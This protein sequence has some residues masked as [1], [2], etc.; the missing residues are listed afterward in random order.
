[1][2]NDLTAKVYGNIALVYSAQR[3]YAKALEWNIKAI[4]ILERVC[5]KEHLDTACK[6]INIAG[7]YSGLGNTD[8]ALEFYGKAVTINENHGCYLNASGV[9]NIIASVYS[10]QGDYDKALDIYHNKVMVIF[11]QRLNKKHAA[12]ATLCNNIAKVYARRGDNTQALEWFLRAYRICLR[13]VGDPNLDT[14]RMA[15]D[16]EHF[17]SDLRDAY[18]LAGMFESPGKKY[19]L[20]FDYWLQQNMRIIDSIVEEFSP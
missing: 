7:N 6:Y 20:V 18:H 17:L 2:E 13:K 19:C 1:M 16:T 8:K 14:K 12:S 5:G 10:D 15:S 9:Y 11:R 4:A 3:N